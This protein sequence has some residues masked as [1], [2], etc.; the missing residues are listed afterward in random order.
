MTPAELTKKVEEIWQARLK[1]PTDFHEENPQMAA[2]WKLYYID[3]FLADRAS[4]Y[5]EFLD[6]HNIPFVRKSMIMCSGEVL[7][8]DDYAN[9]YFTFP[10]LVKSTR[11]LMSDLSWQLLKSELKTKILSL[12]TTERQCFDLVCQNKTPKGRVNHALLKSL[13]EQNLVFKWKCRL[14]SKH[15]I[16]SYEPM[17]PTLKEVWSELP[18]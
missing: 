12:S 7:G 15:F 13:I 14:D 18:L 4:L 16:W 17:S 8:E 6:S 2:D 11:Q 5:K 3:G 9:W 10:E 1:N